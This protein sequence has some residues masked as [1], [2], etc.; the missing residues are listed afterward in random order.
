MGIRVSS[1]PHVIFTKLSTKGVVCCTRC[2]KK[3]LPTHGRKVHPSEFYIGYQN[4]LF[5]R[6][7]KRFNIRYGIISDL[8]GLVYD[9][10]L[11]E[12]YDLHP[13]ALTPDDFTRLGTLIK[14]Q[15]YSR[16]NNEIIFYN[17]SPII[18]SPYLKILA[19]TSLPVTYITML[20]KKPS[21]T[22]EIDF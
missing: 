8:Y 11:I 17:L 1:D 15:M 14:E 13:S 4:L 7:A 6:W 10:D 2:S 21:T 18:A 5:Y 20:P 12:E 19:A 9:D 22:P 3:K 16:R